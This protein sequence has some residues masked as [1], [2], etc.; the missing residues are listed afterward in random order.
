VY[1]VVLLRYGESTRNMGNRFTGWTDVELSKRGV[2][3]AHRSGALSP[4]TIS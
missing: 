1:R 4:T 2:A 3:E